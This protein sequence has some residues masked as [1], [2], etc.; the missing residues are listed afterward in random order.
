M[1]IQYTAKNEVQKLKAPS[2]R[3]DDKRGKENV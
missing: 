3:S 2:G 1:R